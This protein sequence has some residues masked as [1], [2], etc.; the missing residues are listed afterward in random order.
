MSPSSTRENPRTTRV[1]NIVLDAAIALLLEGGA[2][3]VTATRIADETGVARTTIYRHW[4][5]QANLLL[6]TIEALVSSGHTPA[7][8]GDVEADLMT[9]LSRLRTRLVTRPV[10]PVFAALVDYAARDDAFA[11]AQHRF[12]E[13]I[14]RPTIDVVEEAQR[15]GDLP[16]KLDCSLA[17]T[18]L[19]GPLVHQ[20]LVMGGEID[21]ALI[22]QA[23]SQF[24][25]LHRVR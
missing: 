20:Y 7:N 8:S 25:N 6:A 22:E 5:E 10:R 19:A 17:G 21:D 1:R 9:E 2:A 14:I 16:S 15:R 13:G 24:I 12:V 23:V 4:P 11:A 18:L 3:A